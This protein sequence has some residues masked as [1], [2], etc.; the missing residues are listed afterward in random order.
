M[1][2][3]KTGFWFDSIEGNATKFRVFVIDLLNIQ[4]MQDF[5]EQERN[6]FCMP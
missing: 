6:V 4:A 1:L 2:K 3:T 5:T